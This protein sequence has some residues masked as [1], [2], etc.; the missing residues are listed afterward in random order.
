MTI[1]KRIILA[2]IIGVVVIGS[3]VAAIVLTN[4]LGGGQ[5]ATPDEATQPTTVAPT[6]VQPTTVQPTTVAPTTVAPTNAAPAA[7]DTDDFVG[8]V[9]GY[10][11][12]GGV[13]GGGAGSNINTGDKSDMDG[14][15]DS[16]SKDTDN[17][18]RPIVYGGD[19]GYGASTSR[20]TPSPIPE[21]QFEERHPL[22]APVNPEKDFPDS[23]V[24]TYDDIQNGKE[25]EEGD[26]IQLTPDAN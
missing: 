6:T 17:E 26:I 3:L 10:D 11:I 2:V 23:E 20:S 7:E 25:P 15:K 19:E 22:P 8:G 14:S 9:G 13:G 1:K 4:V 18:G 24:I 16:S 21:E 12:G 5:G